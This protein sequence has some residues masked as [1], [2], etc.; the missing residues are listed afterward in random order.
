MQ[1][2]LQLPHPSPHIFKE[3]IK[4]LLSKKEENMLFFKIHL[5]KY[6]Y[7]KNWYAHFKG[8]GI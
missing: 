6:F 8:D 4:T 5:P 2:S 1:W 3:I 7:K